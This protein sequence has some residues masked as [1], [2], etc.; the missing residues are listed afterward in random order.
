MTH[1]VNSGLK[2]WHHAESD[3]AQRKGEQMSPLHLTEPVLADWSMRS[4]PGHT[5][6]G[7]QVDNTISAST[8]WSLFLSWPKRKG[9]LLL[10]QAPI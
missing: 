10:I 9:G 3:N 7:T 8:H 1:C 5:V 4:S 6:I 2:L